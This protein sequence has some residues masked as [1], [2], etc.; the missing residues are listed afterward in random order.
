[1]IRKPLLAAAALLVVVATSCEHNVGAGTDSVPAPITN[2]RDATTT[3]STSVLE[4]TTNPTIRPTSTSLALPVES[5]TQVAPSSSPTI[6]GAQS[7]KTV[8]VPDAV[9]LWTTT[10]TA[11]SVHASAVLP[12]GRLMSMPVCDHDKPS[13][14]GD[15]SI[16]D[17]AGNRQTLGAP[18]RPGVAFP[19]FFAFD[20][21]NVVWVADP[22]QDLIFTAWEIWAAPIDHP[23]TA[24][25]I[26]QAEP[27]A[28]GVMFFMP[29]TDN[30]I[31]VWSTTMSG[32]SEPSTYMVPADGSK[33]AVELESTSFS[34]EIIWPY[35][36]MQKHVGNTGKNLRVDLRDGKRDSL[37]IDTPCYFRAG[38]QRLVCLTK[39]H[40]IILM[41]AAGKTELTIQAA[42]KGR[43]V[44]PEVGTNAVVWDDGIGAAIMLID[45]GK[46]GYLTRGPSNQISASGSLVWWYDSTSKQTMVFDTATGNAG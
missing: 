33:P 2:A 11:T 17:T 5:T 1:M 18:F 42:A 12:D 35:V 38:G 37:D 29:R 14:T 20:D 9:P 24:H 41:D 36:F 8:K 16:V 10:G 44:W 15:V 25:K 32:A 19:H 39:S 22:D 7:S 34:P 13:C 40:D 6:G 21:H 27:N 23:G 3:T 30:G 45:T 26:A 31:V 28:T 43:I 46:I 4:S